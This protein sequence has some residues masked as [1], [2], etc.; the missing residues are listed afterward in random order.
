M[1]KKGNI[2]VIVAPSGTGKSTLIKRLKLEF[3]SIKESVSYT[4]RPPREGE[5]DGVSYNFV[6]VDEFT[7]MRDNNEFLEWAE[8]HTNFYG[9]GISFVESQLANGENVLF[10]L[11]V[12]GTDSLKNHFGDK[13]QVIFVAPPSVEV[14]KERLLNRGTETEDSMKIRLN[15]AIS[16]LTRKDDYDFCVINDDLEKAY[17]NLKDIVKGIIN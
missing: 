16:E 7:K 17:M 8:V 1:E 14:L 4:T 12:Q 6:S 3:P 11:D 9:T 15:N 5:T 13:A 10:D 2:I